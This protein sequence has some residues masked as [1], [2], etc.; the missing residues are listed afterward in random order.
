MRT[1][2][3]HNEENVL[4]RDRSPVVQL[5]LQLENKQQIMLNY[6]ETQHKHMYSLYIILITLYVNPL[7]I[8]TCIQFFYYDRF[9][10]CA[11]FGNFPP[12]L[13]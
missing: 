2:N 5:L 13:H 11:G 12:I 7:F 6:V 8:N 10:E 9:L 4:Y 1:W 3:V